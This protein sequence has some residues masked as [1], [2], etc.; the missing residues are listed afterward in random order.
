MA[1]YRVLSLDEL[2]QL[3]N[4]FIQF[5]VV[6]G[7]HVDEWERMKIDN[8]EVSDQLIVAFSDIVLEKSL[9]KIVY[10]EVMMK[11]ELLFFKCNQDTIELIGCRSDVTDLTRIP[12]SVLMSSTPEVHF[13]FKTKSYYPSRL[14]EIYKMTTSGAS[15]SD[16]VI[17]EKLK[18]VIRFNSN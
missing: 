11:S 12:L 3:K 18:S 7:I 8:S 4:E 5:L 16:G 15:I 14:E 10:L 17:F 9:S 1:K 2:E 13:F 6:N